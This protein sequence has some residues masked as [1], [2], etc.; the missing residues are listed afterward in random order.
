MV[1]MQVACAIAGHCTL[2]A[3]RQGQAL[4]LV[5]SNKIDVSQQKAHSAEGA[6]AKVLKEGD[7]ARADDVEVVVLEHR[8]APYVLHRATHY[9]YRLGFY[10][11]W[12]KVTVM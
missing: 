4:Q 12:C 3:T 5:Y 7:V 11:L 9:S 10:I 6:V 1:T 2:S 8:A